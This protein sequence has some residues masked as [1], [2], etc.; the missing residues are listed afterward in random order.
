LRLCFTKNKFKKNIQKVFLF[1]NNL[2]VLQRFET[3]HNK[4]MENNTQNYL[5][6]LS[7]EDRIDYLNK[8][9]QYP[10][11]TDKFV[12][13]LQNASESDIIGFQKVI[14]NLTPKTGIFDTRNEPHKYSL[15]RSNEDPYVNIHYVKIFGYRVYLTIG[16]K[17]EMTRSISHSASYEVYFKIAN[18]TVVSDS[19]VISSANKPVFKANLAKR[20][21]DYSLGLNYI[22]SCITGSNKHEQKILDTIKNNIQSK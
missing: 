1:E 14:K 4:N 5:R 22:L 16:C 17:K 19:Q 21:I 2:L 11:S 15:P 7:I 9:I 3:K 20:N 10:L 12:S 18:L 8:Q 13:L 6:S